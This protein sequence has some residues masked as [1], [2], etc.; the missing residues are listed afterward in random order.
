MKQSQFTIMS[1]L[2]CLDPLA[3]ITALPDEAVNADALISRSDYPQAVGGFDIA[4]VS[5]DNLRGVAVGNE[6]TALGVNA[7]AT[8][9]CGDLEIYARR[10]CAALRRR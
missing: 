10:G 8:A 5:A 7:A 6:L 1:L 3:D 9:G 2:V 4:A